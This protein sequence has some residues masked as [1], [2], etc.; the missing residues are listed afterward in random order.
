MITHT[1][2]VH[3][4]SLDPTTG[5]APKNLSAWSLRAGGAMAL[6]QGGFDLSVI[7]LL[8]CWKSN[9]IMRYLHQQLLPGFKNLAA[10]MVNNGT[11][12]FLP[13]KWV[14]AMLDL[15]HDTMD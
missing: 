15:A 14:P 9:T 5:I 11:Y 3:V 13:D 10:K 12:M 1:V 6:L 4:A 8:A 7:K 2:W